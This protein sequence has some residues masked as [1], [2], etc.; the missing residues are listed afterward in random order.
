MYKKD[1]Y[2]Q[3][4]ML[5]RNGLK[6]IQ[7]HSITG[8]PI[9]TLKGWFRKNSRKDHREYADPLQLLES[10]KDENNRNFLY[11]I[12][13]YLLGFYLI[14]G[15]LYEHGD[16]WELSFFISDHLFKNFNNKFKFLFGR[17]FFI[18]KNKKQAFSLY[19]KYL[20]K[21]FPK[22]KE[23]KEWQTRILNITELF[24][25]MVHTVDIKDGYFRIRCN[26]DNALRVFQGCCI[27]LGIAFQKNGNIIEVTDRESWLRIRRIY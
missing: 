8:V 27:Q 9:S 5:K 24:K 10:F 17:G 20:D 16:T 21:L 3:A 23:L 7:V 11:D 2:E 6:T 14:R 22:P 4:M 18:I 26:D 1:I 19:S 13:S 25:G 12:Y 15:H